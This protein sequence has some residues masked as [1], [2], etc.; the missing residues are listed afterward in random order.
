MN[1]K[2]INYLLL[3]IT[4]II[5]FA[6]YATTLQCIA[7]GYS[8]EV[9]PIMTPIINIIPLIVGWFYLVYL[10][11]MYIIYS[12][13]FKKTMFVLLLISLPVVIFNLIWDLNIL[14]EIQK[15][16]IK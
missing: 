7:T 12:E 9:N 15:W 14:Y 5:K 4:I 10:L 3:N 8:Y 1:Y 13:K 16:L 6:T 2:K 11:G